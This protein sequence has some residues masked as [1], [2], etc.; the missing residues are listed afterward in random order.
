LPSSDPLRTGTFWLN[1]GVLIQSGKVLAT[2][3]TGTGL[4]FGSVIASSVT[5]LS[6]HLTLHANA[7]IGLNVTTGRLNFVTATASSQVHVI[8]GTDVLTLTNTD[9]ILTKPLTL[10]NTAPSAPT[11]AASKAYVD[12]QITVARN[13][14]RLQ[15]Q[16]T[17]SNV[18][19]DTV[20]LS[21]D[22]PYSGTI[23]SLT[24]FTGNGSFNVAIQINGISVT[25]LSAVAVSSATAA[26]VNATAAK[27]FTAGQRITALITG[28]TGSPT[29]A[30]LSLNV[31]WS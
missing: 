12:G 24:Y 18:S 3:F 17:N 16:W 6:K 13:N 26:T 21:Y 25:G 23:N 7:G 1:N 5:D 31:T 2:V 30:L 8:G 28:S 29:D 15:V 9:A 10:P 22:T 14:A 27:T 4:S 20:W 19:D 11:H